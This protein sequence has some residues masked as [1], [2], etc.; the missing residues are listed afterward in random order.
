[1]AGE[2]RSADLGPLPPGLFRQLR[3][4]AQPSLAGQLGS[5][6]RLTA[7]FPATAA[8]RRVAVI[9]RAP[10]CGTSTI[11]ALLALVAQAYTDNRVVVLDTNTNINTGPPVGAGGNHGGQPVPNTGSGA[12][13]A[14]GDADRRVATL[15]GAGGWEGSAQSR[16]PALL[17]A[18]DGEPVARSRVRAAATPGTVV[19]V[20]ALPDDAGNFPPQTLAAA[21]DR[22]RLRAD[23]LVLDTPTAP[24][25]PVFHSALHL[26]DHV[27]LVI[28]ADRF[29][30]ERLAAG[31][32]W[33]AA[34]PGPQRFHD[35]SVVLV[36]QTRRVPRWRPEDLP[37]T[38][39]RRDGA[40]A[41]RQL[42]R[43]SRRTT[44]AALE[45]L[46]R[47]AVPLRPVGRR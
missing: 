32:D 42:G 5:F 7:A 11:A 8:G 47:V 41:R 6:R 34:V 21:V 31:R 28:P 39:L 9:G 22:L 19:P 3:A 26:V 46:V 16:L 37:W 30:P 15:L 44:I 36:A 29:A 25:R 20:L 43:M 12:G 1:M 2:A 38:L 33:L 4:A 27:L 35:V 23:L 17:A 24:G 10:R 14:N 18:P 13:N 45:L 40:L